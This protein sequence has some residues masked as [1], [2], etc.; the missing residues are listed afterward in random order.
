MGQEMF[1]PSK[2][3]VEWA[4]KVVEVFEKDAISKGLAAISVGNK[5][6]DIP[7]YEQNKQLLER[8]KEI[9]EKEKN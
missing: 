3:D 4:E 1:T 8:A 2:A 7:V 9:E 6:V 5:M